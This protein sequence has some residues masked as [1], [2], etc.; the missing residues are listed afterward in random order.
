MHQQ[1][2]QQLGVQTLMKL[3][4]SYPNAEELTELTSLMVSVASSKGAILIRIMMQRIMMIHI[5]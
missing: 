4:P 2:Y 3:H 5:E 1:A